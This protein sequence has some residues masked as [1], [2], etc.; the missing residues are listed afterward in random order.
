MSVYKTTFRLILEHSPIL[1]GAMASIAGKTVGELRLDIFEDKYNSESFGIL[2]AN[3]ANKIEKDV[4]KDPIPKLESE[5]KAMNAALLG[6]PKITPETIKQAASAVDSVKRL[7]DEIEWIVTSS[8]NEYT[9]WGDGVRNVIGSNRLSRLSQGRIGDVV[10]CAI[11]NALLDE[12]G[13]LVDQW[14]EF[15]EFP[16]AP[17]ERLVPNPKERR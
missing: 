13:D 17:C 9:L 7:D 16:A 3:A 14:G 8:E 12:R 10:Y 6:F 4:A 2:V 1:S 11:V 5:F 15:V